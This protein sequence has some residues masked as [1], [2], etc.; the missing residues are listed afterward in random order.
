MFARMRENIRTDHRFP[1][2]WLAV[3]MEVAAVGVS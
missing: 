2:A 1:Q 3:I